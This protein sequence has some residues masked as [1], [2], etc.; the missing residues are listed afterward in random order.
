MLS[1][2]KTCEECGRVETWPTT[3]LDDGVVPVPSEVLRPW[4]YDGAVCPCGSLKASLCVKLNR[5]EG[6]K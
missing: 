3:V 5:L 4:D 6:V 1:V 2:V